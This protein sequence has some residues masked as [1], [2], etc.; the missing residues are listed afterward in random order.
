[1]ASDNSTYENGKTQSVE[2]Q[3]QGVTFPPAAPVAEQNALAEHIG[4]NPGPV[5]MTSVTPHSSAED[6]S[7]MNFPDGA[8]GA[9]VTPC[10][11]GQDTDGK[12]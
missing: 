7:G 1:M 5:L 2:T 6:C 8:S 11:V 3:I 4:A 9:K 10:A 12:K